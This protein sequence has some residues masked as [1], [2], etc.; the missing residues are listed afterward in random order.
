MEDR[1]G[2]G[3]GKRRLFDK[4]PAIATRFQ[5]KALEQRGRKDR[6]QM[7][8]ARPA[9]PAMQLVRSEKVHVRPDAANA[10]AFL[11]GCLRRLCPAAYSGKED[12]DRR[13]NRADGALE[14]PLLVT[15]GR[16]PHKV[17]PRV[18]APGGPYHAA[19]Y[20]RISSRLADGAS[21]PH[22]LQP[23]LRLALSNR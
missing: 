19:K 11:R 21:R 6:C 12:R 13:Q 5:A 15:P 1:A 10:D 2:Q 4:A 16:A 8:I 14:K 3:I 7:F 17:F 23:F 20:N 9:A 22:A 18:R